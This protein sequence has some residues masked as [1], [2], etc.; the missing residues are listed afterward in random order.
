MKTSPL[1]RLKRK[2]DA[3][4]QAKYTQGNCEA[5]NQPAD[6][7]HHWVYKSQS[8]FLR[9]DPRNLVPICTKHH[10][11]IHANGGDS[12]V[13]SLINKKRGLEWDA[14]LQIDR[15]KPIKMNKA[16]LLS[17]IEQLS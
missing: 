13:Y 10:D 11:L 8:N 9:Y 16:Y 15:Y 14:Q 5:C 6:C 17:I 3:L 2:A 1:T 12:G 7:V 4:L